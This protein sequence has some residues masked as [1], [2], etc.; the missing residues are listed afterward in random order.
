MDGCPFDTGKEKL[1]L[2]ITLIDLYDTTSEKLKK[3]KP[4]TKFKIHGHLKHD[5]T[6]EGKIIWFIYCIEDVPCRK[7]IVGS[8]Q[9]PLK[10][11]TNQENFQRM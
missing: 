11:Y 5:Y 8:T 6:P 10:Q 1:T 4:C 9:D 7:H 3:G 2:D